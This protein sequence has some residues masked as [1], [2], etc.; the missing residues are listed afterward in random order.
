MGNV[1][2]YT[3]FKKSLRPTA[4]SAWNWMLRLLT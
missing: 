3:S 2:V 1:K 4:P